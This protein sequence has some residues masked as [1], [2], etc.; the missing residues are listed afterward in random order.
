MRTTIRARH[1]KL[2]IAWAV[3]MVMGDFWYHWDYIHYAKIFNLQW[4]VQQL[5]V[6]WL[7][8]Q[9]TINP[10]AIN[11]AIHF[12]AIDALLPMSRFAE[13][14]LLVAAIIN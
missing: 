13:S 4:L 2:A 10:N 6:E 7:T 1:P 9:T 3:Q 8:D 5:R 14:T 11:S 12:G